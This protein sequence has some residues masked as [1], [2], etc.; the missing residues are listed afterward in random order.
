[1]RRLRQALTVLGIVLLLPTLGLAAELSSPYIYWNP[2]RPLMWA[3]FR[4]PP[5]AD[6][7]STN[8]VAAPSLKIEWTAQFSASGSGSSWTATVT[9]LTVTNAVDTSRSWV[10]PSRATPAALHHE[11]LHFDLNEVYRRL[12]EATLRPLVICATTPKTA[13][14]TL[15]ETLNTVSVSILARA[16]QTQALFDRET[17]HGTNLG[18]Q[19]VWE[20]RIAAWLVNPATAP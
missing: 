7:A 16:E 18:A 4:G 15:N 2:T 9:A 11:Q 19:D 13:L 8:W 14:Q 6:V 20:E 12:L 1:M 3:D 17:S 10:L 5:P